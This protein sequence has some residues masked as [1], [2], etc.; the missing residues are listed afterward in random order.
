[1]KVV[2]ILGTRPEI[3]RLSI[4]IGGSISCASIA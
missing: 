1:M 3:I 4:V 2:T